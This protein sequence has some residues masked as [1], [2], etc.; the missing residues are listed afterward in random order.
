MEKEYKLY[1]T[2]LSLGLEMG[3]GGSGSARGLSLARIASVYYGYYHNLPPK[4]PFSPPKTAV[5][6]GE[7]R[8]LGGSCEPDGLLGGLG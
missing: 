5:L 2:L 1:L 3:R 7:I 8:Y 4:P 6:G